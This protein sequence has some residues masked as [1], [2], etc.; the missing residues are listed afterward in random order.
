MPLLATALAISAAAGIAAG[1]QAP[2]SLTG[3]V[4]D[5]YALPLDGATVIVRNE[6]TGAESRVTSTKEG[7]YRFAKLGPGEYTLEVVSSQLGRAHVDGILVAAGHEARVLAALQMT[8]PQRAPI[9]AAFHDMEPAT[10]VVATTLTG[11]QV[12]QPP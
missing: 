6:S 3:K 12:Q 5:W 8:L 1:A 7:R 2:G 11:E 4:T 10:P 9:Q